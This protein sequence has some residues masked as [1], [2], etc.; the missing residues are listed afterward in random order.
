MAGGDRTSPITF[1][2]AVGSFAGVDVAAVDYQRRFARWFREYGTLN[3]TEIS[4][5][6]HVRTAAGP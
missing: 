2:E 4:S 6:P 1:D 5:S 3:M